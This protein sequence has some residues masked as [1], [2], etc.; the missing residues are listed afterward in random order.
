MA[1]SAGLML[2]K[3]CRSVSLAISPSAPASSTPVGPAPTITNVSQARRS[4][5]SVSRSALF[6][7]QQ[8]AAADLGGVFDGLE[9]RRHRLPIVVAEV[10][11][12]RAGGQNQRVV[13]ASPSS[14]TTRR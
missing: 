2:R 14:R 1:A 13:A 10:M 3:S 11:M 8:N 9:P 5:A 12:M 4:A 6:K 7:R